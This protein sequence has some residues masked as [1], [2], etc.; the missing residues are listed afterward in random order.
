MSDFRKLDVWRMSHAL[1]L[2]VHA[3]VKGIRGADYVS[4]RSQMLRAA[5]SI[6][7]NV[8]E[9]VGQK[10]AREFGRFVRISINSANEL[11]YH[12]VVARDF[13]VLP[14]DLVTTLM[15]QTIQVRKM[16]HGLR[17]RIDT[18]SVDGGKEGLQRSL[19]A[20]GNGASGTPQRVTV[21]C[22]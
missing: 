5:M 19:P 4:L 9:G 20:T 6:P 3:A 8:V 10:S 14:P 2:N 18:R 12:L 7:A 13:E 17:R 15:A 21:E 22:E 16:L 11:E 1:V